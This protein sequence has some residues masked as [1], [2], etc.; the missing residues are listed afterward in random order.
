MA[1]AQP[2]DPTAQPPAPVAGLQQIQI[3]P[4]SSGAS[5]FVLGATG[6]EEVKKMLK[7]LGGA[8]NSH[9]RGY[10]FQSRDHTKVC[11]ALGQQP[12]FNLVDPRKQ[13]NVQFT[14]KYQWNGDMSQAEE[15]LKS[16]GMTK[17]GRG[18]DWTGDLT[19]VAQFNKI[20]NAGV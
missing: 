9:K 8:Y 20:F 10:L 1:A 14:G 3:E 12:N 6:N 2:P 17:S 5:F 7:D 11:E 15:L 18:N 13:I 19:Q 4:S 16:I